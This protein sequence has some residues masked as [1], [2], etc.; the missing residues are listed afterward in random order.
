MLAEHITGG[1]MFYTFTGISS[2]GEYQY[3]VT[4]KLFR[5]CGNVGA[6]LDPAAAIAIFNKTYRRHGLEPK[7]R[8]YKK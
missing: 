6:Q 5:N 3:R 2:T 8:S 4:L 1:E 7:H